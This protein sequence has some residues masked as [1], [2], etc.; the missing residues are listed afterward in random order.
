MSIRA[1]I[2]DCF[3]VLYVDYSRE[4]YEKNVKNYDE[5]RLQ[6]TDLNKQSD[7]GLISQE[8]WRDAVVELT[9]L[10]KD[11]VVERLRSLKVRNEA[12][13]EFSQSLREEYKVGMLSNI[14]T[15]GMDR[16]FSAKDR[17]KLFDE[18]VL[19]SDVNLI[20]PHPEIFKLMAEKLGCTPGE[21]VMIDDIEDNCSGADAAG[22]QAIHYTSNG[23]AISELHT[24][25][26]QSK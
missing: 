10:N 22:M 14:G 12:L 18:V 8:E 16:Y 5:L 21:C 7:Y 4:F 23:Q 26:Q 9:K 15:G 20:K 11:F 25:L 24:L 2:F 13:L 19:S 6:L 3:G 1:V 17:A